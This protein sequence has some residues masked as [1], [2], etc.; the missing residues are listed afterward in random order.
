MHW[1]ES[2]ATK[3]PPGT[4]VMCTQSQFQFQV[5]DQIMD[6]N[7]TVLSTCSLFPAADHNG[8]SCRQT[9][10]AN[11]NGQWSKAALL[12]TYSCRCCRHQGEC[13][14][15]LDLSSIYENKCVAR[16]SVVCCL[17]G[18]GGE[19]VLCANRTINELF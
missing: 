7:S 18:G 11:V 14:A 15:I 13:H 3:V 10:W 1:R 5:L 12:R 9:S 4:I 6:M 16:C 19:L 2:F 8:Q 17:G